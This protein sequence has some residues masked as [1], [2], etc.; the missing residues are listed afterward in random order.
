MPPRKRKKKLDSDIKK[1]LI[2]GI[3]ALAVTSGEKIITW[4]LNLLTPKAAPNPALPLE[5]T[6]RAMKY[7]AP[8]TPWY[9]YVFIVLSIVLIGVSIASF[10]KYFR[11]KK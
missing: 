11:L 6:A 9:R 2:T 8:S 10:F 7:V 5:P 4:V 3:T 1:G